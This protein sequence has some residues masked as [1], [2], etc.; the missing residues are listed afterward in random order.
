MFPRARRGLGPPQFFIV[1]E[2]NRDRERPRR[3]TT[4][5]PRLTDEKADAFIEHLAH[6]GSVTV[7]AE[8]AGVGRTQM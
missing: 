6:S 7:A 2:T 1:K 5:N 8:R 4:R 3:V